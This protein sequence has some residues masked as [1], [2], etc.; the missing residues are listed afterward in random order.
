MNFSSIRHIFLDWQLGILGYEDPHGS[1]LVSPRPSP[2]RVTCREVRERLMALP[3]VKQL[4]EMHTSQQIIKATDAVD[5]TLKAFCRC[6]GEPLIRAFET[7]ESVRK[8][9]ESAHSDQSHAFS[10]YQ[11]F[12]NALLEVRTAHAVWEVSVGDE[13]FFK[14]HARARAVRFDYLWWMLRL[15]YILS[16]L[17]F[18]G[19]FHE[20][21]LEG[22]ETLLRRPDWRD[23]LVLDSEVTYEL[24]KK[25][26]IPGTIAPPDRF[27]KKYVL[28]GQTELRPFL[29]HSN[30]V[31]GHRLVPNACSLRQRQSK[32]CAASA[33]RSRA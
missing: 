9:L 25:R 7:V 10:L 18:P 16:D 13:A 5:K 14:R 19:E 2:R 29:V 32:S 21:Y 3:D 30:S 12:Q 6:A 27:P 33:F 24:S 31:H 23:Q 26:A 17:T 8:D 20:T 15:V 28:H 4:K 11:G 22:L 1:P